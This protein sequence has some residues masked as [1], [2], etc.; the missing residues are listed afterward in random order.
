MFED[1]PLFRNTDPITS[2]LGAK[3]VKPRR[4]SQRDLLLAAYVNADAGLT[5]ED[6]GYAT[7]LAQ[8]PKCCYWKRCSELRAL[9]FIEPTGQMR[10]SSANSFQM[11]CAIT[12]AGRAEI[13]GWK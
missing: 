7:G 9:G 10:L 4:M 12:A 1:L 13:A 8:K 6:A 2:A 3:D 11:V 5:D